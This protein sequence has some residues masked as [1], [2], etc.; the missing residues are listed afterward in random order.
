MAGQ[1]IYD[2]Y[3][4]IRQKDILEFANKLEELLDFVDGLSDRSAKKIYIEKFYSAVGMY[5]Y[6]SLCEAETKKYSIFKDD[7][8][9]LRYVNITLPVVTSPVK[10]IK[11][12]RN[13]IVELRDSFTEPSGNVITENEV[14]EI[15]DYL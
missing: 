4:I 13:Y 9:V 5:N 3:E 6:T 15:M 8:A 1:G 11:A 7:K 12:W 14:Y 2:V 10:T